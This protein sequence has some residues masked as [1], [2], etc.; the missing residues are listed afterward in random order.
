M[1]LPLDR[2]QSKRLALALIAVGVV[3]IPDAVVPTFTDLIVNVP[4]AMILADQ[5]SITFTAALAGTF[6]LGFALTLA[7]FFIYPYNTRKLMA[8]KIKAGIAIIASNPSYA[9]IALIVL[10]LAWFY[11]Q[12]FYESQ[13]EALKAYAAG[14]I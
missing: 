8:S 10:V 11:G 4:L 13:W 3:L 12:A 1:Y 2:E 9:I 7:G 5:L 6:L 14:V